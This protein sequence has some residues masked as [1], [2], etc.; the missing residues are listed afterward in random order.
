MLGCLAGPTALVHCLN[1]CV[2]LAEE[3]WACCLE[4]RCLC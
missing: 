4:G 2:E 1:C 3:G